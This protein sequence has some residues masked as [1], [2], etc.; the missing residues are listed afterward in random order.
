M[1]MQVTSKLNVDHKDLD[2]LYK[3]NRMKNDSKLIDEFEKLRETKKELRD[4]ESNMD[5]E[6]VSIV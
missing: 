2:E 1:Y 3:M 6:L 5:T 4:F